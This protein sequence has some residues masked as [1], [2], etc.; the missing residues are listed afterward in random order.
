M[1]LGLTI[2]SPS[3]SGGREHYGIDAPMVPLSFAIATVVFLALAP[4]V[5]L[6]WPWLILAAASAVQLALYLHASLRGKF[7]IWERLL[8]DAQLSGD[9]RILDLGCGRGAV[10]IAAARRVP[11]GAVDGVDLWRSV[12]QS[13]NVEEAARQ[14]RRGRCLRPGA[15]AHR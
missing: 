13:G 8:D 1:R 14:R 4:F 7:R 3:P 9:E 2:S 10:T 15:A 6:A 5:G 11:R 12:D